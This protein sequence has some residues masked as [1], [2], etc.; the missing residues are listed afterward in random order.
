MASVCSPPIVIFFNKGFFWD[1]E[2]IAN[3]L[4]CQSKLSCTDALQM[5]MIHGVEGHFNEISL[6]K[7]FLTMFVENF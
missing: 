7:Y 6:N 5:K 4:W 1:D 2:A 3:Y